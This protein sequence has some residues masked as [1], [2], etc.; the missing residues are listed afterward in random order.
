M[1]DIMFINS[2]EVRH[3]D[4]L[5]TWLKVQTAVQRFG[6]SLEQIHLLADESRSCNTKQ[7]CEIQCE[8]LKFS[9]EHK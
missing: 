4:R 3:M 7:R 5:S 8:V 1:F 9:E 6:A 2:F